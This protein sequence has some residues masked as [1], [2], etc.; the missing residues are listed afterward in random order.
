MTI[1]ELIDALK[2]DYIS[3]NVSE[4][5]FIDFCYYIETI[6]NAKKHPTKGDMDSQNEDDE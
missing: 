2:D 5:Q 3:E 1:E 6:V 4:T